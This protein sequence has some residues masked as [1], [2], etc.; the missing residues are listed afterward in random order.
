MA[1]FPELFAKEFMR[2]TRTILRTYTGPH[3]ATLLL[4]CTV[5]LLIVPKEIAWDRLPPGGLGG[6][7]IS[8]GSIKAW[9]TDCYGH[10]IPPTLKSLVMRLRNS[11]AHAG[12]E[13]IDD[14]KYATA[15]TFTDYCEH[16]DAAD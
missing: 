4:N 13:P 3:D 1:L 15:F 9:G 6:W 14:G 10:P 2:R 8:T 7:G 12:F 11:I 16:S 5:G